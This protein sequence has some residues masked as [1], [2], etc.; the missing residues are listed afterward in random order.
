MENT[1][2]GHGL[3]Y[4]GIEPDPKD[5]CSTNTSNIALPMALQA[6]GKSG[7]N[8]D[9][10][11]VRSLIYATRTTERFSN[12]PE[13]IILTNRK[14]YVEPIRI[15]SNNVQPAPRAGKICASQSQSVLVLLFIFI[16][17]KV[18][19]VR[20]SDKENVFALIIENKR[21]K[22]EM[23]GKLNARKTV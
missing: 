3:S 6:M 5:F 22:K 12:Q 1:A 17:S 10:F 2:N 11:K 20:F 14:L 23:R 9:C 19:F 15:R 21:K 7:M 18:C 16:L 13:A 4:I 8:V